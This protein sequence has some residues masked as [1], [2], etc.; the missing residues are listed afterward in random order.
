MSADS[1]AAS[2]PGSCYRRAA[3]LCTAC[4]PIQRCCN[5]LQELSAAPVVYQVSYCD[6]LLPNRLRDCAVAAGS[7]LGSSQHTNMQSQMQPSTNTSRNVSSST[8]KTTTRAGPPNW[9]ARQQ[10]SCSQPA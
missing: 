5:Q 4:Q 6:Q 8:A 9:P 3:A 10:P 7:L 1:R 2:V